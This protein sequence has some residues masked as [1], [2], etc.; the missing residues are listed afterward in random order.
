MPPAHLI[1]DLPAPG[2]APPQPT[3]KPMA[4]L[5][6]NC[7]KQTIVEAKLGLTAELV[8]EVSD[9]PTSFYYGLI[10][11]GEPMLALRFLGWSLP[12]RAGLWW[13][14]RCCWDVMLDRDRCHALRAIEERAKTSPLP[15]H[16]ATADPS[17]PDA[18][19]DAQVKLKS[20]ADQAKTS[21]ASL[22]QLSKQ[23]MAAIEA[24]PAPAEPT[25][26][27]GVETQTNLDAMLA[28]HKQT[29]EQTMP[30]PLSMVPPGAPGSPHQLPTPASAKRAAKVVAPKP[31]TPMQLKLWKRRSQI[32]MQ[33]LASTLQWILD[34]S[35]VHA[36]AAGKAAKEIEKDIFAKS[37]AKAA[38]WCG[39]NLNPNPDRAAV[40]PPKALPLKGIT[41]ALTKGLDFPHTTWS[42]TDKLHWFLS[43]G[44]EVAEGRCIWDGSLQ[45]FNH[46]ADYIFQS[47]P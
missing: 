23:Y 33:G 39:E 42:R 41:T 13:A 36:V 46:Y 6:D 11:A 28:E 19:N 40:P 22:T 7:V 20:M 44:A 3:G 37:L 32:R 31:L 15:E 47:T 17:P 35:Q 14:F 34:P 29:L 26:A 16:A 12:K 10:E 18:P 27:E 24:A 8:A 21:L 5:D 25:T 2:I 4:L 1:D 30:K 9:D 38:F 45:Q 43:R